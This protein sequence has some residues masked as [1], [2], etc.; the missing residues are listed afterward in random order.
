MSLAPTIEGFFHLLRQ[1]ETELNSN[2][3]FS[4]EDLGWNPRRV[5]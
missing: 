5:F 1:A 4:S 3:V 2:S